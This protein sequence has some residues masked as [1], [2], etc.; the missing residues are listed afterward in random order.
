MPELQGETIVPAPAN[1]A[2]IAAAATTDPDG[3]PFSGAEWRKS[4][5]LMYRGHLLDSDTNTYDTFRLNVCVGGGGIQSV[6][7]WL[8]NRINESL[9]SRVQT[10]A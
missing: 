4:N 7:R 5:P 6:G 2:V 3:A 9:K 8:E 10:H 1:D